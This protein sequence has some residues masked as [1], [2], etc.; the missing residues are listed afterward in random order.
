MNSKVKTM[1]DDEF[2][3][4]METRKKMAENMD[5]IAGIKKPHKSTKIRPYVEIG[6][7]LSGLALLFTGLI[8]TFLSIAFFSKWGIPDYVLLVIGVAM[9][10]GT[11]RGTL[12]FFFHLDTKQYQRTG[13]SQVSMY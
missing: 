11:L 7:G 2:L 8:M 10:Y 3:T 13:Y 1:T 4:V 6:I 5:R 9:A 12:A